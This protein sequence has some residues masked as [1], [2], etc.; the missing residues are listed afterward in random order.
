MSLIVRGRRDSTV[1]ATESYRSYYV[2]LRLTVV[3][4]QTVRHITGRRRTS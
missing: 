4:C 1:A 2:L 3:Y